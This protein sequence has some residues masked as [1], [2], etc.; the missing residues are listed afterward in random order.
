M[1]GRR[2]SAAVGNVHTISALAMSLG[3]L[4][5]IHRRQ[6]PRDLQELF[7][8]LLLECRNSIVP[9]ASC[10]MAANL[11]EA[12]TDV[13][14]MLLLCQALAARQPQVNEVSDEVAPT[15]HGQLRR[16]TFGENSIH[17]FLVDDDVDMAE[18]SAEG[19]CSGLRALELK[20]LRQD[21]D[22]LQAVIERMTASH[23]TE[24]TNLK[25]QL[26][27]C[28]GEVQSGLDNVA[29]LMAEQ[30]DSLIRACMATAKYIPKP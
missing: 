12:K 30:T 11:R 27:C 29:T 24:I 3:K 22:N 15:T 8:D 5:R 9:G 19:N 7:L 18:H 16:V 26:Q 28:S 23:Q 17:T 20:C 2:V 14:D 13:A 25:S 10:S 1:A 4:W 6:L 21:M